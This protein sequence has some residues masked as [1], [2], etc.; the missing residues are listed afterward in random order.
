M[1]PCIACG[2]EFELDGFYTHSQMADGHLNKCKSCCKKQSTAR[3]QAK[4]EEIKAYDRKRGKLP[5]RLKA[6][7]DRQHENPIPHLKAN[8]AYIQ[9]NPD[10]AAA[11][12][13]VA[14]ALEDGTLIKQ[15]CEVC[16][17]KKVHGHHDDYSKPLEV[18]W[19]CDKHHKALHKEL[20]GGA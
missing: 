13:A 20:K 10:K 18:K 6:N 14:D 4:L 5:H 11:W 2:N 3:R 9:R 16:G 7:R 8:Q 19:L 17:E 12:L 15:P 1:K